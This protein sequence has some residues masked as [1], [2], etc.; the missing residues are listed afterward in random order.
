M[1]LVKWQGPG[2]SL[3]HLTC[4]VLATACKE[5]SLFVE[6]RPHLTLSSLL[7]L[8]VLLYTY[9][10][11]QPS[12]TGYKET[13][14]ARRRLPDVLIMGVKK[15]GTMSLGWICSVETDNN[16]INIQY[17]MFVVM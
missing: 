1:D 12:Q 16:H 17:T 6:L 3:Q 8:N 11:P 13:G 15:S 7:I 14:G 4:T 2:V 5:M 9:Y 10:S